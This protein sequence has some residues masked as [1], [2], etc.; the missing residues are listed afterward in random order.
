VKPEVMVD[1]VAQSMEAALK[2]RGKEE[3]D[4]MK[5]PWNMKKDGSG[6]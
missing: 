4:K 5:L 1:I 3:T 6:K 2:K